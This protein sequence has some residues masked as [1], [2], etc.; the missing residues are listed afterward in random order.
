MGIAID[1]NG[2][3][4]VCESGNHRV[5]IFHVSSE[6]VECFSIGLSMVNPCGITVDDDGFLYVA[7]DE[8]VHVF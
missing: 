3:I 1:S 4:Y 6:F 5:S 2:K 8:T 7:C